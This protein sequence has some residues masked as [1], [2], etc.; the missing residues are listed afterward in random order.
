MIRVDI[1]TV[2]A[3]AEVM[4]PAAESALREQGAVELRHFFS[5]GRRL[6]G[7]RRVEA[8]VRARNAVKTQGAARFVMFVDRDVALPSGG[9]ETLVFNLLLNRH[10]A[11]LGINYQ[12][13]RPRSPAPHVA[14]GALLTY[15]R[16]LEAMPIRCAPGRCEC[17]CFGEDLRRAGYGIDYLPGLKAEHLNGRPEAD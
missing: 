1:L 17:S 11:A 13:A 5:E 15:R 8:I 4:H 16:I 3:P 12:E 14:M 6:P 7:E 9:I 2:L 10:H